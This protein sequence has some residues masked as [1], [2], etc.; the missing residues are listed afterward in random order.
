MDPVQ[1]QTFLAVAETG[2]FSAAGERLHSVQ[3]NITARIRRLESDLGGP[4]FDRGKGGA[5]LTPLGAR[6]LPHARDI[7]ARIAAARAELLDASGSAA[8]LRLGALET[9]AGSRLPPVLRAL[10]D[11]LPGAE[12]RLVTGPSGRLARMVRDRDLDAALVVGPVDPDR[13]RA[14]PVFEERLVA[15]RPADRAGQDTLLAFPEGCSYRAAAEHWLRETGRGDTPVRDYGALDTILGCVGAG[16]GFAVAPESAVQR[17][18]A[19][20]TLALAPLDPPHGRAVTSLIWRHDAPPTRTT[21]TLKD[22]LRAAGATAQD[23]A[24]RV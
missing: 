17:H 22:I 7:L 9:T 11:R 5:R 2:S 8:P 3:S 20:G 18:A 23:R 6:L 19:R 15:I 21:E 13:F 24:A 4:L 10:A 12:I 16:L 1:L 14:M